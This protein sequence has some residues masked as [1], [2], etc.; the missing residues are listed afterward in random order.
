M[1]DPARFDP[2]GEPSPP[3]RS[4]V[5]L[6]REARELASNWKSYFSSRDGALHPRPAFWDALE[7]LE[8]AIGA[9]SPANPLD[10]TDPT[11][12]TG[13]CAWHGCTSTP[14]VNRTD[15]SGERHGL[16][17][18]H[19]SEGEE[20]KMWTCGAVRY[21][22]GAPV[23]GP[24]IMLL[25]HTTVKGYEKHQGPPWEEPD[26]NGRS[27][28]ERSRLILKSRTWVDAAH[29]SSEDGQAY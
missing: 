22:D 9:S 12:V 13:L 10:P 8:T 1:S 7:T 11:D 21:V 23:D 5:L 19:A 16:C 4:V 3:D 2:I 24:C 20:R 28:S 15:F 29:V 26:V 25:G 17:Y 6:V 14:A 27:R 18:A